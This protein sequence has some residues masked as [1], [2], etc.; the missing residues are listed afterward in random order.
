MGLDT[1]E[2]IV[3][4]ESDFG[5]SI[6]N[7]IAVTLSTPRRVIDYLMQQPSIASGKTR[8]TVALELWFLLEDQLSIERF[9][10]TEDSRFVEDMGI[11]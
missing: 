6:P 8:E 7:E 1:V 9:R 11:D 10:Y 5:V 4:I 2:L 3:R